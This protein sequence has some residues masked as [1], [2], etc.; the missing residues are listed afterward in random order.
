[1]ERAPTISD[2]SSRLGELVTSIMTKA[3]RKAA[4]MIPLSSTIRM[5]GVV[6]LL[7]LPAAC[8]ASA[9]WRL[10]HQIRNAMRACGSGVSKRFE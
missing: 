10:I 9:R 1:M 8:R 2:T 7:L 6:L 3:K 5:I 4:F